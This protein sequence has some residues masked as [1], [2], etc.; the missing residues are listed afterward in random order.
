MQPTDFRH[1]YDSGRDGNNRDHF[2]SYVSSQENEA[3]LATQ[4]ARY[5]Q[6]L[7]RLDAQLDRTAAQ[8][9]ALNEQRQTQLV[10]MSPLT[11]RI[12]RL[13]N[14]VSAIVDER[15]SL[16]ARRAAAVP[17]YSL[18]GGLFFI[19]AGLS[20]LFGDLIISH[21]IVAYALNIR[22][23]VEAWAFAVGLAMVTV[24]LKPAYDR[25][26][27]RPY[28]ENPAQNKTRYERFKVTLAVF[29]LLTLA[30]LG[31]FRYE[32]YRT[33]QLKAAIN[34][35]IRQLQQN[36]TP[37]DGSST[38]IDP[39]VLTK[40]EQQ[41]AQSGELNVALVSSP[42]AMLSFVLSG[43]LFA[44]AGAVCLGIGL[45]VLSAYWFRWLQVDWKLARLRRRERPLVA[46]LA[47][48]EQT[49]NEHAMQ[50]QVLDEQLDR[51]PSETDLRAQR[52]QL[53][54]TLTELGNEHR[55]A[56]TD[57]RIAQYNDGY[58]KGETDG[59]VP[60]AAVPQRYPSASRLPTPARND[61]RPHE[62]IRQLLREGLDRTDA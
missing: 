29:A 36:A 32:A 13:R 44:L 2:E 46:E 8:R 39:A 37:L 41:L 62:A 17:E 25:L 4:V 55:L 1:G 38:A 11:A 6:D 35:S 54:G 3:F 23:N 43:L 42:W 28:Q 14:Q 16:L 57:R 58:T 15:M 61:L 27:E 20:F 9:D 12:D 5:E 18:L 60:D 26:I 21:E 56:I 7:A 52:Q 40:I 30:V 19:A 31:W 59:N 51:L 24:L 49:L 47:P 50:K 53:L 33:D 45:P 48:L 34:R 22:D 10:A